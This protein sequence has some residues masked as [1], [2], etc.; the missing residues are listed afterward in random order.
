MALMERA[1][2]SGTTTDFCERADLDRNVVAAFLAGEIGPDALPEPG[3]GPIG[4]TVYERTYA[5][6]VPGEDRKETWAE[7][8]RRVVLGNLSHAPDGT[9]LPGEAEDLFGLIY[10]FG[11]IPAGRHLWVTGV[12]HIDSLARNCFVSGWSSRTSSHFAFLAARLFEGGGVGANYSSDL[13][14]RTEPIRGR[15]EVSVACA[16]G[17][18][19]TDAIAAALPEGIGIAWPDQLP[20][21]VEVIRVEDS[22]EGWVETWSKLIDRACEPGTRHIVVDVSGVRPHGAPLRHFGGRASGPAPLAAACLGIAGIV[23]GAVGRRLSGLEAMSID[24]EIAAAVVAGGAR[25][26]A[27]LA[28]MHW[29]DPAIFDFINC[30]TDQLRHW[31][32][33]ISVEIDTDFRLAIEGG[34]PHATAVLSAVCEGMVRN[35]EPGM[36]DTDLASRT[37]PVRLRAANPCLA[38]DTRLLTSDGL[39]PIRELAGKS[40]RIWNGEEWS[41]SEAWSTGVK[42]VYR[43][44]VS[45]GLRLRAT[46]DHIV[47]TTDGPCPVSELAG[48]RIRTMPGSPWEGSDPYSPE[49]ATLLGLLHGDGIHRAAGKGIE[50]KNSEPEVTRLLEHYGFRLE[51][52][53]HWYAGVDSPV[54]ALV[55]KAGML[56]QRLEDRNLPDWL[57][58]ATPETVMAFLRGLYSANGAALRTVQRVTLKSTC[59]QMIGEV[60]MLLAALGISAYITTNKPST[61]SW[62]NG[63]F[64]SRE[65]YDLNIGNATGL[66]AFREQIGF[67]HL[68]KTDILA[69]YELPPAQRLS[70]AAVIVSVTPAGEEEVYDF[71]EPKRHWGWAHGFEVHNCGESFL[72]TDDDGTFGVGDGAGEACNL[73]S[74]DL[75][76]FADDICAA[77]DAVAL[78]AR[79]LYRATCRPHPDERARRIEEVNRRIGV[80]IMGLQGWVAAHGRRL[81]ELPQSDDL[82]ADL[83]W[84]RYRARA[85]ADALADELGLPRPVKVTAV[86]PTGTIAQLGGTTP[87]LHPVFARHFI[88][89]V[90]F[91]DT[92][93]GLAKEVAAGYRVVDDIYAASTK[94]VEYPM[95][96]GILGRWPAELIEQSDE[97]GVGAFLDLIAAVQESF[98][99]GYDGQ[100]VSATAAIPEGYDPGELTA[101]IRSRLG[102]LKGF[103]VF[104]ALSRDLSP[105]EAIDAATYET[106]VERLAVATAP[107]VGDSNSGEC[108]GRACPIR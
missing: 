75:S 8:V 34:D 45:N 49:E 73:G 93:P 26:S 59:R 85:S 70:N 7:T 53:G 54:F 29:R 87:G 81:S 74:V 84:L 71:S 1:P 23:A 13:I 76:R 57:F 30:K 43:V 68:H 95:R 38:G 52:S 17:H 97:I 72:S 44:R 25:R 41:R 19:D 51:P 36:L 100:A 64:V 24:H 107:S 27:R 21:G 32:A 47:M 37:E 104:P 15:I 58:R 3:W 99:G 103:T 39:V 20:S 2:E 61:I 12:P 35:G 92:D 60:Q 46:G 48:K 83:T 33:N 69:S 89:R 105:Y 101:A 40:F 62:P 88:R 77:G 90:R 31:S 86:A 28:L 91:S 65:S 66:A 80:G 78:M 106:L 18:P 42:P 22:R 9:H 10:S 14:A 63:T 11:G 108:A 67:L 96:D 79:V 4:K 5:R 56:E 50:I 94:V 102:K 6:D 82:L 98:V 16:P 55:E